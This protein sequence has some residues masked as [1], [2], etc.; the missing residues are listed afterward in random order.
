M[1]ISGSRA[2]GD[3]VTFKDA[4]VE[5]DQTPASSAFVD[6][7]SWSSSVTLS[8][9]DTPINNVKTYSGNPIVLP[10][11]INPWRWEVVCVYTEGATDPALEMADDYLAS[12]GLRYDCR[13]SPSG[14]A[15]GD[16]LWSST[17]GRLI[18]CKPVFESAEGGGPAVFRFTIESSGLTRGTAS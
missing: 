12:P 4:K 15:S 6:I 3:A 2:T 5:V 9:G 7:S 8:G 13:I 10:G 11:E 1:A 14:G 16:V 17:G 18:D